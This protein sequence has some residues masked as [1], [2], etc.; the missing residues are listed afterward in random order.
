LATPKTEKAE[1]NREKL[2]SD[3]EDPKITKS[4][5]DNVDPIRP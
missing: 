3:S 4:N 2:R 1:P 5:T